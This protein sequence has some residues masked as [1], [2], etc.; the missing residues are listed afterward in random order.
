MLRR[1]AAILLMFALAAPVVATAQ[2]YQ[3]NGGQRGGGGHGGY[4]GPRGGGYGG[5]YGGPG[6]YGGGPRGGGYRGYGPG[7]E[8]GSQGYR[9]PPMGGFRNPRGPGPMTQGRGP[10]EAYGGGEGRRWARGQYI[11]PEA[12]GEM[13]QD[14]QRYHLRRPPRGYY[15]YRS[16]DDFILAGIS[17][18]MVFE[19]IPAEGY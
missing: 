8:A 6:G 7:P 3:H 9:G 16:G 5:G 13:V 4:G 1:L 15:W 17:T 14:F 12:R 18:G 10:V 2:G 19:V 11:P